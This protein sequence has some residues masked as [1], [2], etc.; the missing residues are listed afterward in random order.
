[1]RLGIIALLL[2][3]ALGLQ[4]QG[5]ITNFGS[6]GHDAV[7]ALDEA[8]NGDVLGVGFSENHPYLSRLSA[9]GDSLWARPLDNFVFGVGNDV[10]ATQDGN[11]AAAGFGY[12]NYD[13]NSE[14]FL[15][16][17]D[18][19]GNILWMQTYHIDYPNVTDSLE[20]NTAN[21]LAELSDGGYALAGVTSG[22]SSGEQIFFV[23]TDAD[24]TATQLI[25]YGNDTTRYEVA[26]LAELPSG[27]IA[28]VG[29]GLIP[30]PNIFPYISFVYY[31]RLSPQGQVVDYAQY[32]APSGIVSIRDAVQLQN[33]DFV[34]AGGNGTGVLYKL[35]ADGQLIWMKSQSAGAS[36]W[37]ALA[38][39]ADG[40]L[41]MSQPQ[42]GMSNNTEL[43]VQ[44]MD[45]EANG[46]LWSRMIMYNDLSAARLGM[47]TLSD[48]GIAIGGQVH[49]LNNPSQPFF[50]QALVLKT[51]T[52]GT[53]YTGYLQGK[54]FFDENENCTDEGEL[55]LDG[56]IIK[57]TKG[58]RSFY[59]TS[60][61]D[62]IYRTQLDTGNYV[63]TYIAPGP[64][65]Y[66]CETEYAISVPI[67]YDTAVLDIPG[68]AETDCPLLE[69]D[70]SAPFL[71]RCF[72]STYHVSYCN[73]GTTP[74]QGATVTVALDPFLE[75]QSSSIPYSQ[76]D[77]NTFTFGLGFVE[78]NECGEFSITV[79]VSCDA[80]AGQTHCSEAH[81]YPDSLCVENLWEGPVIDVEGNCTP[82]SVHFQILNSG[83]D[84]LLEQ[85]Y[86]V[87]EDNIMLMMSGFQLGNGQSAEFSLPVNSPSTYR[88][89]AEQAPG[90]PSLL[91][92]PVASLSLEGCD[93]L[94]TGFVTLFPDDD[95]EPFVDIDCQE[96]VGAI[97]PN[98]KQAYPLGYDEQ[99]YV[100]PG[101]ELEYKIRFQ[102]T[103]TD[104]AFTVII[105]DTL[106][107]WISLSTLRPGV[108]SH[109]YSWRLYGPGI[110]EFR[111]DDI[112]LP[113][114]TTNEPASHG[115]VS[116]KTHHIDSAPL[117]TVIENSAAIF[118]DYN[119]PVITNT[120]WHTLGENFVVVSHNR[121]PGTETALRVYPNPFTESATFS[122]D[123]AQLNSG[124]FL[125][126]DS[127]G[128]MVRSESIDGQSHT[129]IRRGLPAGLYFFRMESGGQIIATGKLMVQ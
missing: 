59:A 43:L 75:Y 9:D 129:F 60:G 33:G 98:D 36:T 110:L 126:F 20:Y 124:R 123:G 120:T 80:E 105:R 116:F 3:S 63:L 23:R 18:G 81:I 26:G 27:D 51:D 17:T 84:M 57:A 47:A 78:V 93:G 82:D 89:E 53:V 70:I 117:G 37:Y 13:T 35:S 30:D 21:R 125:L 97:D 99:H 86:I 85:K 112:L 50:R 6:A 44:K 64:Y 24:G 5:W 28:I 10:I 119:A 127:Q 122:W 31:L 108:A 106:S 87:T 69:V 4:A 39:A 73:T 114:S 68:Q 34:L 58:Q 71:R 118:F 62:G 115:F 100:R 111:F 15:V 25:T 67:P 29:S 8:A 92:S 76:Q 83:S 102:N 11:I 121:E 52:A 2:F 32:D 77:G 41:L 101:T 7:Q 12:P 14:A 91:G 128:R 55:A 66:S 61:P 79:M 22:I 90:F 72:N 109:P 96:N 74:A 19:A 94:N 65:W 107:E 54:V 46:T 49:L 40:G 45:A 42:P 1:M 48:G 95:G 16:K 113:D 56:W 103:G 104:T 38:E 88:I